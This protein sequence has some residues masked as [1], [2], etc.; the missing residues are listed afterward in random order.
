MEEMDISY[1]SLLHNFSWGLLITFQMLAGPFRMLA[2]NDFFPD[3]L[4][5]RRLNIEFSSKTRYKEWPNL[6]VELGFCLNLRVPVIIELT[7]FSPQKRS[8]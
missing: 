7:G 8:C 2:I 6:S 1:Q 3:F 4:G 5:E